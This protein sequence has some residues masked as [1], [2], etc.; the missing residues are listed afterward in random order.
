MASNTVFEGF[1]AT[2][3]F[4][5]LATHASIPIRGLYGTVRRVVKTPHGTLADE[6]LGTSLTSV[7][8]RSDDDGQFPLFDVAKRGLPSGL[9]LAENFLAVPQKAEVVCDYSHPG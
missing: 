4:R 2:G 5:K 3:L 1:Q 6:H 7:R 8:V 9:G